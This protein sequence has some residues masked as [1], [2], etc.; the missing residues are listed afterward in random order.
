VIPSDNDLILGRPAYLDGEL[1]GID[2]SG[3]PTFSHSQA[4]SDGP[5]G[6]S[7]VYFPLDG[8]ANC[9]SLGALFPLQLNAFELGDQP[10]FHEF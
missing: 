3:L 10:Y 7:R 2:D 1:C 4:A 5:G 9:A 6:V 8:A